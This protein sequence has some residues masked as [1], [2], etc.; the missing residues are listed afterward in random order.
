MSYCLD[1]LVDRGKPIQIITRGALNWKIVV[2]S[3]E[4][5]CHIDQI[6]DVERWGH[7]IN[8]IMFQ[9]EIYGIALPLDN[10]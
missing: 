1:D 7:S 10:I 2:S 6:L 9:N 3:W 8:T 4:I 5:L